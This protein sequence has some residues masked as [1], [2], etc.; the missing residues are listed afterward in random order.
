MK[1]LCK[2]G[3][4]SI[5]FPHFKKNLSKNIKRCTFLS[6]DISYFVRYNEGVEGVARQMRRREEG[7]MS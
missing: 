5:H 1:N 6:I 2:R 3:L 4:H 7:K